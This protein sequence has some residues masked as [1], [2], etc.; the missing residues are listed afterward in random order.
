MSSDTSESQRLTGN[1]NGRPLEFIH[2]NRAENSRHVS[3]VNSSSE[4]LR[5]SFVLVIGVQ[6][7]VSF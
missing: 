6:A 7:T 3:L 4:T 1:A 2:E 5:L